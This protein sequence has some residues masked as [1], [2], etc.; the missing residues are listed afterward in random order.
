MATEELSRTESYQYPS[1]H[2]GHL[3]NVQQSR[4][5]AFK[6]L[7]CEEGGYYTPVNADTGKPASHDDET[8]L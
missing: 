2:V 6:K 4:L 1:A 3:S 5:D 8:L 7:L